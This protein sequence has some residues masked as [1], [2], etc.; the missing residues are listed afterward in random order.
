MQR[1]ALSL[2][3]SEFVKLYARINSL[4]AD[5]PEWRNQYG[6][7]NFA[8]YCQLLEYGFNAFIR[9]D[10]PDDLEYLSNDMIE[11]ILLNYDMLELDHFIEEHL[12]LF[13]P[14]TRSIH[15]ITHN[16]VN[17]FWFVRL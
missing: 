6:N 4:I 16:D 3:I 12:K 17:V 10:Y 15:Y 8:Q 9:L 14:Q 13:P 11:D 5:K 1:V 7:L 2:P